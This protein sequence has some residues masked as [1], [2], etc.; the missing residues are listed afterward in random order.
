[1]SEEIRKLIRKMSRENPLG[2]ALPI[3]G[4]LLKLGVG[5]GNCWLPIV[6][7]FRTVAAQN[8]VW[9]SL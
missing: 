1:M 9:M 4:E 6:D 7:T 2:G 8:A 5:A 3:Y